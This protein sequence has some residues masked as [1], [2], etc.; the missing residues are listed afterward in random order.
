M[1]KKDATKLRLICVPTVADRIV[2]RALLVVIEGDSSRLGILNAVSYGFVRDLGGPKRGVQGAHR[3]AVRLRQEAPWAFKADISRFF[4]TIQR[5]GLV[6]GFCRAFR[7]PSLSGLIRGIVGS[8]VDADDP[9]VTSAI[10][11]NGIVRGKGLRQGMPLSPILSNF[12]LRDFD[13]VLAKAHNMVRYAVDLVVFT[14]TEPE[15]RGAEKLV[16]EELG[17]LGLTLSTTKSG[18]HPPEQAVEFLGMELRQKGSG[19]YEL[20]VSEAQFGQIRSRFGAYHDLDLIHS[21]GLDASALF[22]RLDQMR[23]GYL[24][25]YDAADNR[26][27]V[28]RRTAQWTQ[29]C[30]RRVYG[31]IFGAAAVSRLSAKQRKFLML[32]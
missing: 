19:G 23:L 27:D 28:E 16:G 18:I 25:A 30:A 6:K 21:Q 10:A 4:D 32:S 31:S 3:L 22:R 5:D 12:L 8:E 11:Q 2:Q 26:A 29:E 7:R 1:P 15:C 17:K 13:R 9:R 14:R 20:A 24:S